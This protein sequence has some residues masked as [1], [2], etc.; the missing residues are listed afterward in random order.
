MH[1]PLPLLPVPPS[2]FPG[3]MMKFTRMLPSLLTRTDVVIEIRDSRLPLTSINRS[4]EGAL[5]KWRLERGWDAND[6]TRRIVDAGPCERLV[7]LNKRDLVPEWG[8]EP[9]RLAMARKCPEQQVIFASWQRPRD[10]RNLSKTLVDVAHKYPHTPE[11]NVLVIGMPNV[12]K[13]TLLNALRNMGI[14]G[15]T[16]KAFRTSAQPGLTQAL[17][18]RLKL[19]IDPL[20]YAFD[21]PGVMLP[22]LGQGARGAERGVKLAL[23]AGIKEGMYDNETLASYLLYRLNVLNPI[24]PAYLSLLPQGT[25]PTIDAGEFLTKLARR[26]GMVK[27]GAELDISRAAAYFV[28]WWREEGGLLTA[29]SDFPLEM[30][31]LLN[32]DDGPTIDSE[33]GSRNVTHGWGFDFQWQLSYKEL[34]AAADKDKSSIMDSLIQRK[35]E[36]CIEQYL[37]DSEREDRDES[38]ISATQRKKQLSMEEKARRR[39]KYAKAKR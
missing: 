38:N 28:R 32:E 37:I 4:L 2:W 29:S 11:L 18:T 34:A 1:I 14:K 15:K 7:V 33:D 8:M 6:P 24:S 16:P 3:H 35:M 27:R 17:S 39:Q 36:D 25:Q 21:T 19:S 5:R 13:S 20:V 31:R 30:G 9:F 12:G 26:M 22:F 23:I 10:I